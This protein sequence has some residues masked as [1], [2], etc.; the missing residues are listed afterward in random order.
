LVLGDS[1]I[2]EGFSTNL[3]NELGSTSGLKFVSLAEPAASANTWYY[4]VRQVDP[5]TRRYSAI[6]I[7][8]GVGYEPNSADPLR[9]SMTAPL[10]RY[11]DSFHFASGFQRWSGRFR[12]F[13]ACI[14]RGSAYQDD[15]V[16]LLEH[17][18]SR[19]TSLRGEAARK[20]SREL[21]KGRDYD[22]VGTSYDSTTGH[23]TFAEKLTEAQRRA[24][25][26]SLIQPSQ[27]DVEYSLKLQRDWIPRIINRYSKSRTS[28]VLTPV[29]R[30]PFVELP[31]FSKGYTVLPSSV[32]QT[33]T[34]PVPERTFDFL[35]SPEYY[36]DA[37]H[38]NTK[39]RERFTETLVSQLVG[40]FQSASS[41]EEVN[42]GSQ[43]WNQPRRANSL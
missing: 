35:E 15:V 14:L 23:V 27:S 12:A 43:V 9:I 18:I 17:P 1:R 24:I 3:A 38:L 37:F 26:K 10:L 20:H 21:Y 6:V 28:I 34:F 4:M 22:L 8:Y 13:T 36:F 40:R 31:G 33:A 19:I 32:I 29:P 42:I 30:G 11:G 5:T 2:A 41:N 16:D 25:Q 7:P 39:G